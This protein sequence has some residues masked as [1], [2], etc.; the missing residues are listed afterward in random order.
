MA[1]V[2]VMTVVT[3]VSPVIKMS[4]VTERPGVSV[5]AVMPGANAAPVACIRIVIPKSEKH[6]NRLQDHD[7]R[8]RN[9]DIGEN[10]LHRGQ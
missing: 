8:R 5:K 3:K 2:A 6:E 9:G 1:I 10:S 7:N 4:A